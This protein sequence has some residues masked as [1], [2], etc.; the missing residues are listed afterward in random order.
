MTTTTIILLNVT[1]DA[2]IVAALALVTR[3]PFRF[4]RQPA[5]VAV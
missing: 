2:A 5:R 3:T 1:L 4:G